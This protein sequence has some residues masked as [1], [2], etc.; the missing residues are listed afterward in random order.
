MRASLESAPEVRADHEAL[1]AVK[2][3]MHLHVVAERRRLLRL[4]RLQLQ[5]TISRV[6]PLVLDLAASAGI[7]MDAVAQ[8]LRVPPGWRPTVWTTAP[9]PSSGPRDK[10]GG[11]IARGSRMFARSGAAIARGP[12]HPSGLLGFYPGDQALEVVAALGDAVLSTDGCIAHLWLPDRLPEVLLSAVTGRSIDEVASHPVLDGRGYVITDVAERAMSGGT[13]LVFHPG[14]LPHRMPWNLQ[15]ERVVGRARAKDA[16][17]PGL[18]G[19][20]NGH[21]T[22]GPSAVF[23][24]PRPRSA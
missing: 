20:P 22:T 16:A 15:L 2:R 5:A 24:P 4:Y 19:R 10:H 1:E 21:P 13:V 11:F 8:G 23:A 7:A 12:T 14:L 18:L 3:E 9:L 17:S 6:S